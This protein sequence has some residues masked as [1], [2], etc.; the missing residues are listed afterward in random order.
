MSVVWW[1]VYIFQ[2]SAATSTF[3][4]LTKQSATINLGFISV[5]HTIVTQ[6]TE[7]LERVLAMISIKT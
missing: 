6:S 2:L 3:A 7:F 5:Q 1:V 4:R